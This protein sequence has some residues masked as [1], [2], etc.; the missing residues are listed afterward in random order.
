MP[1][2]VGDGDERSHPGRRLDVNNF[3]NS[4]GG[5]S[6]SCPVVAGVAGLILSMNPALTARQ[7]REILQ[8]TADKIIDPNPDPQL[9]LRYGT[10]DAKSHSQWFGYG[11]VN[12]FAA[13]KEAQRRATAQ[14]RLGQVVQ[15]ANQTPLTIPDNQPAGVESAIT[16]AQNGMVADLQIQVSLEHEF[17]GDISVTL[18]APSGASRLL[19]GRTLGQQTDLKQ[20][21]NLTTTPSLVGLLGQPA[22]GVWKLRIVDHAPSATGRLLEWQLSLGLG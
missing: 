18:V 15:Q 20:T 5:T 11:K 6:S 13:V 17:L 22:R 16:V 19:Q 14:R 8:T 4:F 12:A 21:Y 9:G 1:T 2:G 7:V 10:Y 3:T